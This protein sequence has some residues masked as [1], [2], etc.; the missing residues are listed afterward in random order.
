MLD[1]I[2]AGLF[3]AMASAI[4]AALYKDL[5][6]AHRDIAQAKRDITAA[7]EKIRGLVK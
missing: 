3:I 5:Q 2:V 7:F 1:E 6:R 4:V